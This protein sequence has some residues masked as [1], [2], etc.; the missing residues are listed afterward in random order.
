[1]VAQWMPGGNMLGY[2]KSHPGAN[3]LELVSLKHWRSD[4]PLTGPQL[5]GVTRGLGYLHYNEVVHGDL[6]SVRGVHSTFPP[7]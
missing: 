5:L 2:V 7:G 4:P 6:K 1:M 3:R